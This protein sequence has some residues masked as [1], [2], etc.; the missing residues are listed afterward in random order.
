[1][2]AGN[3]SVHNFYVGVSSLL[4]VSADLACTALNNVLLVST[5]LGTAG[6]G[7][8]LG[9]GLDRPG[10]DNITGICASAAIVHIQNLS[11]YNC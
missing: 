7:L 1:L 4:N 2:D 6:L 11:A 5:G 10:L 8:G 9:L 3:Y